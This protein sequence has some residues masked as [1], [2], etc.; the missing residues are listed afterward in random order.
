MSEKKTIKYKVGDCIA[1]GNGIGKIVE[2]M[3]EEGETN[4]KVFIIDFILLAKD[5]NYCAGDIFLGGV[6][7]QKLW[8]SPLKVSR[9]FP[10]ASETDW[11]KA[12]VLMKTCETSFKTVLAK[13]NSVTS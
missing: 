2:L 1:A 10:P 7:R 3:D 4:K 12:V 5:I 9:D 11:A 8:M 13:Y 6:C